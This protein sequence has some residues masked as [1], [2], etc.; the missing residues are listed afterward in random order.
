MKLNILSTL[1]SWLIK[2]VH[3]C[4]AAVIACRGTSNR[5]QCKMAS[6]VSAS[7][8][9]KLEEH[10]FF[11]CEKFEG[12]LI[13]PRWDG[14]VEH[15]KVTVNVGAGPSGWLELDVEPFT[16][17]TDKIFLSSARE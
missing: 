12:N 4:C 8:S 1:A 2:A 16:M 14:E 6:K 11:Q 13:I 7:S 3:A 5:R 9:S 10:M 15:I 17:P